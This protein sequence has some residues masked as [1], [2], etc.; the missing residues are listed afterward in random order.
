[1]QKLAKIRNHSTVFIGEKPYFCVH[2]LKSFSCAKFLRLHTS[3]HTGKKNSHFSQ[4]PKSCI[5]KQLCVHMRVHTGEKRY[6]CP[7]CPKSFNHSSILVGHLK[8]HTGKKPF[9]GS[10][11]PQETFKDSYRREILLSVE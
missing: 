8:V 3:I 1:M 9:S 5:S 6:S 2:C 4:C 11:I 10:V 7:H